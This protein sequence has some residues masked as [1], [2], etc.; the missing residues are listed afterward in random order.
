M[1]CGAY[2]RCRTSCRTTKTLL[3]HAYAS[4]TT[5][6]PPTTS[7]NS[8]A[9]S[10]RSSAQTR[11][12]AHTPPCSRCCPAALPPWQHDACPCGRPRPPGQQGRRP[13]PRLLLRRLLPRQTRQESPASLP[14]PPQS[15]VRRPA[16]Q[17]RLQLPHPARLPLAQAPLVLVLLGPEQPLVQAWHPLAQLHLTL[18]HLSRH[19]PQRQRH[20]LH[21]CCLPHQLTL[22]LLPRR[23]R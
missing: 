4:T 5:S 19:L 22:T 8:L 11:A 9:W 18:H 7:G 20:L 13:L 15:P 3:Q 1:E 17:Q 2:N 21:P 12:P 10:S 23:P 6:S 16:R 14:Q